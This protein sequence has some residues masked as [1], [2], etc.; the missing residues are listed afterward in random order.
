MKWK[1]P[2]AWVFLVIFSPILLPSAL[3]LLAIFLPAVGIEWLWHRF[4]PQPYEGFRRWFAWYPVK[5]GVE[6][7]GCHWRSHWVWFVTVER[8]F[9]GHYRL[10][11][12][13]AS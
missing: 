12:E 8:T 1:S 7:D 11:G 2:P 10:L 4:G 13:V 5:I 9:R 3:L 6:W